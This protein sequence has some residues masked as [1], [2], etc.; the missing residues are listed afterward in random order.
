MQQI[1]EHYRLLHVLLDIRFLGHKKQL[2]AGHFAKLL[3]LGVTFC[4]LDIMRFLGVAGCQLDFLCGR[5]FVSSGLT[6][7]S[8]LTE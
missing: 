5:V 8:I 1:V 4:L 7:A 2:L 6:K 3:F